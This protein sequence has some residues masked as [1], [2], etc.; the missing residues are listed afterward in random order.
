MKEGGRGGRT[1]KDGNMRKTL[2]ALKMEARAMS[3]EMW[4]AYR[5]WKRHGT[6]FSSEPGGRMY[7]VNTLI[8]AQ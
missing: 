8:L 7:S 2:L 4:V 3:Q 6:D 1:R 5:N